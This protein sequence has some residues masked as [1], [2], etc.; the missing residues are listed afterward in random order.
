ERYREA[1]ALLELALDSLHNEHSHVSDPTRPWSHDPL[2]EGEPAACRCVLE[3]TVLLNL[4]HTYRRLG[5][6]HK[7]LEY[8]DRAVASDEE[9]VDAI[10]GAAFTRHLAY[11][12]EQCAKGSQSAHLLDE[13]I[14]LYHRALALRPGGNSSNGCGDGGGINNGGLVGEALDLALEQAAKIKLSTGSRGGG[15]QL[16][17]R[18][19]PTISAANFSHQLATAGNA[20]VDPRAVDID[21]SVAMAISMSNSDDAGD[22]EQDMEMD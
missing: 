20:T 9:N 6:L 17:Q 2:Q 18:L 16:P 10:T 8:F 1:L 11:N 12:G 22:S 15:R 19:S 21:N 13:A 4:A 3:I 14:E 5:E 7:S